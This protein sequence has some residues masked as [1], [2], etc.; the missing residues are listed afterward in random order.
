MYGFKRPD[1]AQ[2]LLERMDCL[3]RNIP[4][5]LMVNKADRECAQMSYSHMTRCALERGL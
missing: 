3:I 5:C 4:V 1:K 2:S